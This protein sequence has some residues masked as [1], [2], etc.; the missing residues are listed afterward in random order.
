EGQLVTALEPRGLDR[1]DDG[2]VLRGR[3]HRR[4]GDAAHLG[5]S[6][7]RADH[8]HS[9]VMSKSCAGEFLC[10]A[11]PGPWSALAND[12]LPSRLTATTM[13]MT[14]ARM[15]LSMLPPSLSSRES[16]GVDRSLVDRE[17][18]ELARRR[19]VELADERV[20]DR[21]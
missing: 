10:G 19:D 5:L 21:G 14:N 7:R 16:H 9:Q 18:F 12:A 8:G 4:S 6:G 11:R 17:V 3:D 2:V 20:H 1:R 13:A 15:S